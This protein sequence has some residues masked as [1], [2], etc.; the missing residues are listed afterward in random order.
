MRSDGMSATAN[1]QSGAQGV[2]VINL[3]LIMEVWN[4]RLISKEDI[5]EVHISP[6]G[7]QVTKLDNSLSEAN[8]EE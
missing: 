1:Q 4:Q 2:D 6:L 7:F 8:E 3:D 5:K